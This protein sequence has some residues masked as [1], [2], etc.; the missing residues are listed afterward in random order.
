MTSRKP[1]M[2]LITPLMISSVHN[3]TTK[4]S[5]ILQG[6]PLVFTSPSE[7][8]QSNNIGKHRFSALWNNSLML[9]RPRTFSRVYRRGAA[10][11]DY[12]CIRHKTQA[13]A[14]K[15]CPFS[16]SWRIF[17]KG[18]GAGSALPQTKH[19]DA[20]SPR[21]TDHGVTNIRALLA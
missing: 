12:T 6:T 13:I 2:P 7:L 9:D 16:T 11:P 17:L 18:R 5:I 19:T 14:T 10:T 3:T 21:S 4:Q 8:L 1:R 15:V 20:A